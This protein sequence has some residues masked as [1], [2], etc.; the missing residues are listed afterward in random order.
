MTESPASPSRRGART[1]RVACLVLALVAAAQAAATAWSA[2]TSSLAAA[3]QSASQPAADPASVPLPADPF[4]PH[5][6]PD[7]PHPEMQ[8]PA[9][10]PPPEDPALALLRPEPV[11]S[12]PKIVPAPL[13]VPITDDMVLS[14]LDEALYLRSQGDLQGAIE[15]LRPALARLPDH[16]KL[17]YHTARTL[18][19]MGLPNKA[20]P[21]WKALHQLGK[22]AGTYYSLARDRIADGPQVADEPEE[23]KERKFTIVDL[24]DEKLPDIS[25][26]ERV[27][28]TAVL[29]KNTGESLDLEKLGEEMMLAPHFFDTV[30]GRRLARSQVGQPV[31]ECVSPPLDWTEPETFTFDYWQ[32]AMAPEEIVKYGRC[33]YYGCTLEVFF[34]EK[35]QD[36]TATTPELLQM[37]RELPVPDPVPGDAI[38]DSIPH[39]VTGNQPEAGLFPPLLNP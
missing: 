19:T 30:N 39:P 14:Q 28:F 5:F 23:E 10:D 1:F 25:G 12:T 9:G 6:T 2:R 8:R 29:K 11:I 20:Q 21:H 3:K 18:D 17:L 24:T 13:D 22:G 32:P 38:L 15:R 26:G 16:P 27:R 4:S 7:D 36:S 34:R 37:A 31:L 35:L 33:R